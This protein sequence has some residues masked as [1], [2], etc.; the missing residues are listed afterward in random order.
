MEQEV[1]SQERLVEIARRLR[2]GES[3]PVTTVRTFLGWFFGSQRR[4]HWIVSYI[5]RALDQSGLR[6]EPDF[7]SAYLDAE[8]HFVLVNERSSARSVTIT[9]EVAETITISDHAEVR[10]VSAVF[11]DPTY[12]V[13]KLAAAN[14]R[15]VSVQ[16]D[17]TLAEAVTLM[18][19]NDFSQLPVMTSE[20]TVKGIVSWRSIG[21]RLAL[22]QKPGALREAMEPH[23]EISFDASLFTAIPLI[24]E[25]QYVLVR[26]SDQRITGIVTTSDLSLQFQQLAEPF[27]LLGEVEN[28]LRRI[29]SSHFEQTELAAVQDPNGDARR[30][31]TAADL[32]FGEYK[33]LFEDPARWH[34]IGLQIDRAVFS[35]LVERVREI[36][37]DVM[38]FDPDGIPDD[39]LEVLRDFARFL[40]TLQTLGAT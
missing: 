18:M 32:T 11:A 34:R 1:K 12:R 37:N 27:L 39:D 28:H 17:S 24:V 23:A 7:E 40:R 9:P 38:H 25:H 26:S 29:I 4:G 30:V 10:I 3:A 13:S 35:G 8:M 14:R 5:R 19:A 6:T 36:R 15:P 22:G 2:L 16:P 33:R 31:E 20:R 21:S